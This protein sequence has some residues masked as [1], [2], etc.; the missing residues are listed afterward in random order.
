MV[1]HSERFPLEEIENTQ[2]LRLVADNNEKLF[3]GKLTDVLQWS[4]AET[5][6]DVGAG[7]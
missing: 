5:E 7:Q 1:D 4:K 2:K 3:I 6:G